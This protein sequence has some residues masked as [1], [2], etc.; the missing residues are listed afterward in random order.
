MSMM[1]DARPGGSGGGFAPVVGHVR[2]VSDGQCSVGG[3]A[4]ADELHVHDDGGG[5]GGGFAWEEGPF[6]E[7]AG[8]W[9]S[10]LEATARM[11][12]QRVFTDMLGAQPGLAHGAE[13]GAEAAL[14]LLLAAF[15]L[16]L[17]Y[18]ARARH[19]LGSVAAAAGVPW[20]HRAAVGFAPAASSSSSSSSSSSNSTNNGAGAAAAPSSAHGALPP[21]LPS[22][23]QAPPTRGLRSAEEALACCLLRNAAALAATRKQEGQWRAAKIAGATVGGGALLFVTG[24]LAAP[25]LAAAITAAGVTSATV[26]TLAS[27]GMVRPA[28]SSHGCGRTHT[29]LFRVTNQNLTRHG[30]DWRV[31]FWSSALV[32]FFA[33]AP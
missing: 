23:Q 16:R 27:S 31:A 4:E 32:F 20:C 14:R 1:L 11:E 5:G 3:G 26:T 15:V 8:A 6:A 7:D 33:C 21:L 13:G 28:A 22:R 9:E 29:F 17:G 30:T 25:A 19:V 12:R 18:D 2:N 24:G 10:T